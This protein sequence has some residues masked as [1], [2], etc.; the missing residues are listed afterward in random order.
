[1]VQTLTR[2][3]LIVT[4]ASLLAVQ[5]RPGH[6]A[7]RGQ[8]DAPTHEVQPGETL[9]EIAK[10]Y[11]VTLERLMLFNGVDDADAVMAGQR[12]I[13]PPEAIVT[14]PV[15]TTTPTITASV[16][17]SDAVTI[18]DSAAIDPSL[19]PNVSP[20]AAPSATA[21]NRRYTVE[22]GD[23][24]AGI[25][26]RTGV[27]VRALAALNPDVDDSRL[28]AG[29]E[30]ILPATAADLT[31]GLPAADRQG[32]APTTQMTVAPGDSLS[33]IA[34]RTGVSLPDLMRANA[35]VNRDDLV[36]GQTLLI[37]STPVATAAQADDAA[38][39]THVGPARRGFYSYTVRPGDTLSEIAKAFNTPMLAI[40]EYNDLP[41]T[42]TVYAG[43]DLRIPFGAPPL[44]M[45]APPVPHSGTSFLVSLSRQQCW[46]FHGDTAVRTWN[47]STGY[48][49]WITRTGTFAVQTK[50]DMAKSG[51]YRLDMPY[52]LGIYDVG[53]Y[54]NGIH[55]IPIS[56]DTNEKLWDGLIGQ[57]ATFGCAMLGDE[58]AAELY[59]IAYLGMPVHIIP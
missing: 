6:A 10:E 47:C 43:L 41:D 26:A 1:M 20:A 25:A 18:P 51:A 36:A 19:A 16:T 38:P 56:W 31:A 32:G 8:T 12:L 13:L 24:L 40:L 53:E 48:G 23:T 58:D 35:L 28:R 33:A 21:R 59:K 22:S 55:G 27:D 46:L 29:Q 49:E 30:L 42:E 54:E 39:D 7:P 3:L 37:P 52:W 44:P 34:A 4:V 50:L 5:P 9:S 11:G 15:P 14:P 45:A 2:L 17:M 57:P